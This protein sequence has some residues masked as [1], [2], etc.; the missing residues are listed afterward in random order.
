MAQASS[1]EIGDQVN[2]AL[3]R[4]Q[5]AERIVKVLVGLA[6]AEN[7]PAG[8]VLAIDAPWGSGKSWVAQRLAGML[9]KE[10]EPGR[11]LY[12]NA[13]EFDFHN[14]PFAVLAS[15]V[16]E[17]A[18]PSTVHESL[19]RAATEVLKTATP[20]VLGG[21]IRRGG[22]FLVGK[23]ATDVVEAVAT[24][25]DHAIKELLNTFDATKKSTSAF[26][27]KL[28]EFASE[29]PGPLV[30]VVDELDRCR[31]TFALEMLERIKH[32]FDV[33][34]VVF[35]LFV[36]GQALH[37]AIRHTYGSGIDPDAYLRKFISIRMGLPR[38][39]GIFSTQADKGDL[40]KTFM[41]KRYPKTV[42]L[43]LHNF[44][45]AIAV[46][47]PVFNLTLRDIQAVMTLG[48][49]MR[50]DVQHEPVQAAYLICLRVSEPAAFLALLAGDSQYQH[51]YLRLKNSLIQ[52]RAALELADLFALAA[53]IETGRQ[54]SP[55][56][57][58]DLRWF[59][60]AV[61]RFDLDNI[62]V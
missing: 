5:V 49:V 24:A 7:L 26:K 1:G 2:D 28:T 27:A 6:D 41:E 56:A 34:R 3:G 17:A 22:E 18:K 11:A 19:R 39:V 58:E 54:K 35:A 38:N 42:A 12:I 15:A 20:A 45:A 14:D 30:I 55:G 10:Y 59:R 53:G 44:K 31:P 36:H 23:E 57:E 9:A 21:L 52:N 40:A 29:Q 8:R 32:L 62:S 4:E 13:F 46:F 37:S 16:L 48:Q 47:A 60:R 25:T 61:M 43:D 51:E 33:P 50:S